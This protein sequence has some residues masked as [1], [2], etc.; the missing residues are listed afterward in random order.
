MKPRG[1]TAIAQ[2]QA[3]KTGSTPAA[4]V[5]SPRQLVTWKS[6][7][8][9]RI[10]S[11]ELVNVLETKIT[12]DLHAAFGPGGIGTAVQ[13]FTGSTTNAGISV[14]P[15]WN[16]NIVVLGGKTESLASKLI[17]DITL[18]T[19]DCQVPFQGH[20]KSAGETCKGVV[21]VADNET[22]EFIGASSSGS[23]AK[24]CMCGNSEHPTLQW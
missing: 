1:S 9:H 16:Q 2:P 6:T 12:M 20:L 7:Q 13:R 17:G 23:T 11:D 3:C 22:A 24:F 10:R 21:T 5:E 19:G 14:G 4:C 15:L 18:T 8:T